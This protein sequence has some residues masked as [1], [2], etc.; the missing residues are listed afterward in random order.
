M[1]TF[2]SYA[3]WYGCIFV[4]NCTSADVIL[5]N[6]TPV[7]KDVCPKYDYPDFKDEEKWDHEI[8]NDLII[9]TNLENGRTSI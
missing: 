2:H 8:L 3:L 6:F 9:N 1:I 7:L 4:F 5:F